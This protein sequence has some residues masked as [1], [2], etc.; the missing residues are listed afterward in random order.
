MVTTNRDLTRAELRDIRSLVTEMCAN[1]DI[2]YKECLPLDCACYMFG[3]ANTASSL[4]KYFHSA[5]LPLNPEL[6]AVF[7]GDADF[8]S[9]HCKF[10]GKSLIP[11]SRMMYCSEICQLYGRRRDTA[12]R[13][14]KYRA[15]KRA[16]V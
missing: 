14:R 7:N 6:M 16:D 8:A 11:A 2:H 9:A 4:C 13:T 12:A 1:Y 3:I 5:V 15:R 10:C